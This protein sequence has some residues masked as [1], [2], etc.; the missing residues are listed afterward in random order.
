MSSDR[1]LQSRWGKASP[2]HDPV[3]LA[4]FSP[5]S[6]DILITT[7]PKAGTTW[8]QQIL[9]QLRTG[10]DESFDFIN[11]VVPW[12]ELPREGFSHQERLEQFE[13]M[14]DPRI[15]KTHCTYEQ[16]P[17]VD[18][19]RIILTT[20]DPRDCCISF[21]HH[22]MNMTDEARRRSGLKWPV[23]FDQ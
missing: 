23:S 3:L 20:R 11:Q 9:H 19:C 4:N 8:M 7:A 15:F 6:S 10:G 13:S 21:Y 18:I 16:T 12:L 22:V 1:N 2:L 14:P 5:R 17:G